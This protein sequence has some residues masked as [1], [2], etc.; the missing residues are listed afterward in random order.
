MLFGSQ[1]KRMMNGGGGSK[2]L[3]CFRWL[4]VRVHSPLS[5]R[6]C[7]LST[8]CTYVRFVPCQ[9]VWKWLTYLN[10]IFDR[11]TDTHTVTGN[12][13]EYLT[14]CWQY[15]VCRILHGISLPNAYYTIIYHYRSSCKRYN[16]N[17]PEFFLSLFFLFHTEHKVQHRCHLQITWKTKYLLLCHIDKEK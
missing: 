13:V 12:L 2:W 4:Y 8:V 1:L 14:D 16:I 11:L 9:C 3:M 5:V 6:S 10:S 15:D 7:A 17:L